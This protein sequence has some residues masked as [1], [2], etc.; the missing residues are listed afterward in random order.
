MRIAIYEDNNQVKLIGANE[1][2][3]KE[4]LKINTKLYCPSCK[5]PVKRI[6]RDN[7]QHQFIAIADNMHKICTKEY[8]KNFFEPLN[9][10]YFS[11]IDDESIDKYLEVLCYELSRL[12]Q[13][14]VYQIMRRRIQNISKVRFFPNPQ[15]SK[16]NEVIEVADILDFINRPRKNIFLVAEIKG[17][18]V[19]ETYMYIDL[20]AGKVPISV[21]LNG[22]I[23]DSMKNREVI[24]NGVNNSENKYVVALFISEIKPK[25]KEGLNL[26]IPSNKFI[27]FLKVK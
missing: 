3:N 17:V 14:P 20:E 5:T 1:I 23:F 2:S 27:K 4:Y 26:T 8:S 16:K 25:N 24:K 21:H 6:I 19:G 12:T 15:K 13:L 7:D 11:R 18:Y 9:I 22:D 10:N